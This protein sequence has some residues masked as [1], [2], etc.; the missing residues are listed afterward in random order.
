[1]QVTKRYNQYRRD[2]KI[3]MKCEGCGFI[4]TGASAYDD[5]NFWA[6]VVPD[7]ECKGCGKSSNELGFEPEDVHTKYP[8]AFE[9]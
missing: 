9:V 8:E 2:L 1:M 7:F 4:E 6:N 5:T 3:D